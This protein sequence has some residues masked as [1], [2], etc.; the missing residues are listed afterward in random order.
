M[1]FVFPKVPQITCFSTR[2][3]KTLAF[4]WFYATY[5]IHVQDVF[6]KKEKKNNNNNG[7][8]T[9]EKMAIEIVLSYIISFLS[10]GTTQ[11]MLYTFFN[12]IQNEGDI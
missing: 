6:L 5:P 10:F 7:L 12:I 11:I 3:V 4:R 2:H 9:F 8:D 1:H